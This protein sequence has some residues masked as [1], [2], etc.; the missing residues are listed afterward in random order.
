MSDAKARRSGSPWPATRPSYSKGFAIAVF[1]DVAG[2]ASDSTAP[3][4]KGNASSRMHAKTPCQAI[5]GLVQQ[6]LRCATVHKN[7]THTIW[8]KSDV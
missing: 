1:V 6:L 4:T 3:V 8:K 7:K 5:G 2:S